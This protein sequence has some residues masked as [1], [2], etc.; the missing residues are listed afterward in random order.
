MGVIYSLRF[1]KKSKFFVSTQFLSRMDWFSSTIFEEIRKILP[2][3]SFFPGYPVFFLLRLKKSEKILHDGNISPQ[4]PLKK[5]AY[6]IATQL[7]ITEYH[8]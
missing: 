5:Y 1:W 3:S 6:I 2:L 8:A 4:Q 7:D